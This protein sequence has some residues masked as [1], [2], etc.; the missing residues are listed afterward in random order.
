MG[1]CMSGE[2]EQPKV[3]V[4]KIRRTQTSIEFDQG[5]KDEELRKHVNEIFTRF[6]LDLNDQLNQTELR[7]M[8]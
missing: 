5:G 2:Q 3:R 1:G 7:Q 8:L 6:E 4:K